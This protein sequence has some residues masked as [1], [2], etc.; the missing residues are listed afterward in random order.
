MSGEGHISGTSA[1]W[2]FDQ[3]PGELEAARPVARS[4]LMV[5]GSRG[6]ASAGWSALVLATGED[7]GF[8]QVVLSIEDARAAAAELELMADLL[9]GKIW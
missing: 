9:E 5:C 2:R 6:S 4:G 8:C 1:R 7:G 3:R